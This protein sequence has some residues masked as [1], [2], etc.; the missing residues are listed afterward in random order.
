M[1]RTKKINS[2]ASKYSK[3]KTNVSSDEFEDGEQVEENEEGFEEDPIEENFDENNVGDVTTAHPRSRGLFSN[4]WWKKGVLK[5]FIAWV[6]IVVI[7]YIFDLLK[8]VEVITW[9]RWAFFFI[10]LLIFGMAYE[11]FLAGKV[12]I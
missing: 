8:M 3:T 10:L 1:V 11:K 2:A 9:E 4:I 5:G 6:I 12:Q 7:F